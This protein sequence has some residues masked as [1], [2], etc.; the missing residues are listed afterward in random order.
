MRTSHLS[1]GRIAVNRK[2]LLESYEDLQ[3]RR[4]RS[5]DAETLERELVSIAS[6]SGRVE[7]Q[8]DARL[9]TRMQRVWSTFTS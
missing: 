4:R 8:Q 9:Q 5:S 6:D 1:L 3:D 2:S 7:F